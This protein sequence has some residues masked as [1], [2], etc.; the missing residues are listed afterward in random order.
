MLA[1]ECCK[2]RQTISI[3]LKHKH[4]PFSY[5]APG[6]LNWLCAHTC[7]CLQAGSIIPS[8]MN[9]HGAIGS[10]RMHFL[11]SRSQSSISVLST[12]IPP[13][14]PAPCRL[15][16]GCRWTS[17][18]KIPF[19]FFPVLQKDMC[20]IS[21][22]SRRNS[23]EWNKARCRCHRS[24]HKLRWPLQSLLSHSFGM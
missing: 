11:P 20:Q 8:H 12:L 14:S 5:F 4:T 7:G 19:L 3:S 17:Q 18:N 21:P 24:R 2:S 13:H 1:A 10:T 9:K 6:P 22:G 16:P 15:V 23:L